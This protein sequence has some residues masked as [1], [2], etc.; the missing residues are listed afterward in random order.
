M[1]KQ[2]KPSLFNGVG[3]LSLVEHALCPI[4]SRVSLRPNQTFQ[5]GYFYSNKQRQRKRAQVRISCPL[6]LSPQDEFN[7]WG[8]L[9]ITLADK[10][11]KGE[12][13]ATR[14]YILS[15]LGVIDKGSK[16]GGRQYADLAAS[17]ERLSCVQYRNDAFYDP[18]RSEHRKVSFGFFSYSAPEDVKSC[19]AWRI[20]W[21]PIFFNL[22]EP[23]GGA[24]RF[25]LKLYSELDVASRRLFLFLSKLFS[26]RATTPR[27]E[28]IHLATDILG[29]SSSLAKRDMKIKVTRSIKRLQE[30]GVLANSASHK[31]ESVPNTCTIKLVRGKRFRELSQGTSSVESPLVE[32]LTRLGF[33]GRGVQWLLS[34]FKK[35]LVGQWVDITLAAIERSGMSYFRISPAAFLVDNLNHASKGMRT[36]PDWWHDIRRAEAR[37]RGDIARDKRKAKR[38]GAISLPEKAI[39]SLDDL[40]DSIFDTF[41][42]TGQ[43]QSL[44]RHN[45]DQLL[46]ALKKKTNQ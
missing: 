14:H 21:D 36:P 42:T 17:L 32:P 31:F 34:R 40:Q 41:M 6:G 1:K 30:I 2:R 5:S 3:Q 35:Q 43:S 44:A 9:A 12:L 4:N 13:F 26:R 28:L 22:A 45:S 39:A 19:R 29:Y 24:L 8:L 11:S 23:C 10:Q 15:Q 27:L 37:K 18:V 7:L 46:R 25:N 20:A 16:R 38:N 33:D